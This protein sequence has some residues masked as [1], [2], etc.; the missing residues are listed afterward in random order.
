M[1]ENDHGGSMMEII[2]PFDA[3]K[4]I[5]EEVSAV[6]RREIVNLVEQAYLL[7]KES[8]KDVSF[9]NW[10][11]GK[12]HKGYL[13][14]IAVQYMLHEASKKGKLNF[15]SEISPNVNNSSLHIELRTNNVI[16][17]V[18]RAESKSKTARRAKFR[19]VLQKENQ[20][21]WDL[22]NE[23]IDVKEEPGYLELTH[24]YSNGKVEFVNLGIPDG[25]GKWY[26]CI[27]LTK[28]LYV[29]EKPY[30]DNNTV[31]N[32]QLVKF[33]EFVQGARNDGGNK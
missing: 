1:V 33:K 30:E 11:L 20:L 29:V 17:T 19:S 9:L 23:N 18:N 28:E 3:K 32:Q 15:K 13:E 10:A 5:R 7:V 26:S 25:Q 12:S 4:F 27:D 31:D 22:Y 14:H 21:Y 24:R 2:I 6:E 8:L 16:I